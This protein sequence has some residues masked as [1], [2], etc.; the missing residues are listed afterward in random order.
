VS[1]TFKVATSRNKTTKT[2]TSFFVTDAHDDDEL[3]ARPKAA[4]FAVSLLYDEEVQGARAEAF[5][6]YM[7]KLEEAKK[8]SFDQVHLVDIL[9]RP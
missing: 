4:E 2:V 6:D 7:N 8:A 5:T 3:D 9:S 1:R